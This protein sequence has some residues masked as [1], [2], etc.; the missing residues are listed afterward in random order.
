MFYL[1]GSHENSAMFQLLKYL[2]AMII[3]L[4]LLPKLMSYRMDGCSSRFLFGKFLGQL[5]KANLP[6]I[7]EHYLKEIKNFF[8]KVLSTASQIIRSVQGAP[9]GF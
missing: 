2:Q 1:G 5:D 4:N 6:T 8:F 7:Q 3:Q 9:I